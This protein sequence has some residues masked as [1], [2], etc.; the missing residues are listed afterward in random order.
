[1]K[2]LM[3]FDEKGQPIASVPMDVTITDEEVERMVNEG[4]VEVD[5]EDWNVY[6]GNA[7]EGSHGTGHRRD[8]KGR[9]VDAPPVSLN[10]VKE[11]KINKFKHMRD[12]LELKPLLNDDRL[13]DVDEKSLM[14]M[15][16]AR[17]ALV[18]TG[19]E[20]ITWT[21]AVNGRVDLTVTD[22]DK[23]ITNLAKRSNM[24]HVKY[25]EL[26]VKVNACETIDAVDAI[27]WD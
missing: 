7:G 4:Y 24:L 11:A 10:E 26:K 2:Y 3:R 19:M 1:M 9:P 17:Q 8:D 18:F 12:V 5:R 13:Y 20:S 16:A 21:T 22:F 15:T 6:M 14:R 23:I 27:K 25:N